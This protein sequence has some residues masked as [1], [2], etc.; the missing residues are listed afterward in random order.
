VL[1]L[2]P[3][4][5]P[6]V[7]G[8]KSVNR[9]C[10]S[11]LQSVTDIALQIKGGLIDMGIASGAESM[12]RDYGVCLLRFPFPPCI[13]AHSPILADSRYPRRHLSLHQEL[14]VARSEG[15]PRPHG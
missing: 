9:Q 3:D 6:Y 14:V 12:T 2:L 7:S 5:F 10:A 4:S 15:L 11:S 13:E 1:T 8:F